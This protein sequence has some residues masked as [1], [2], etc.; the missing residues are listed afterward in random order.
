MFRSFLKSDAQ[1]KKLSKICATISLSVMS[2]V[3]GC[4]TSNE[5]TA[6]DHSSGDQATPT[7][8]LSENC[9]EIFKEA[10]VDFKREQFESAI[11]RLL[12]SKFHQCREQHEHARADQLISLAYLEFQAYDISL[13]FMISAIESNQLDKALHEL[14]LYSA[15]KIGYLLGDYQQALTYIQSYQASSLRSMP[16]A[17]ALKARSL[18]ALGRKDEALTVLGLLYERHRTDGQLMRLEWMEF[19]EKLRSES[20]SSA[21]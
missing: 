13:E 19:L 16:A 8:M 17:D 15:A 2:I 4:T 21:G 7:Q 14:S 5:L 11:E 20:A 9:A 12:K 10:V 18:Y 1:Q 3:G 6:T